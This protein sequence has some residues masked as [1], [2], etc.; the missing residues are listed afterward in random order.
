MNFEKI[1]MNLPESVK[2]VIM[3]DEI[4]GLSRAGHLAKDLK[5]SGK[6]SEVDVVLL[7]RRQARVSGLACG[8]VRSFCKTPYTAFH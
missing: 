6:A 2:F 8:C 4:H 7:D 1:K 3:G 5:T